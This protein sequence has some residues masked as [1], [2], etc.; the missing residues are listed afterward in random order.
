MKFPTSS[1][2]ASFTSTELYAVCILWGF[3]CWHIKVHLY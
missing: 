3:Y 2:T 1:G